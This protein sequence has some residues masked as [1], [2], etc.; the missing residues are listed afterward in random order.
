MV[1]KIINC[2]ELAEDA[3]EYHCKS[4]MLS[5][6]RLTLILYIFLLGFEDI[7]YS[8]SVGFLL[9]EEVGVASLW[10]LS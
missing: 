10:I 3:V 1:D 5:N 2:G 9:L 7:L 8:F 6:I 4:Q